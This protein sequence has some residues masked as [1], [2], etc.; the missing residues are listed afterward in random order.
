M[1]D[2]RRSQVTAGAIL[3]LLGVGFFALQFVKGIGDA[4]ILFMIGAL[5]IAGYFYSR[6]YGLLIPGC[7]LLGVGLGSVGEQ[8]AFAFGDL[9]LIGIG[10]GFVSI[11]LVDRIYRGESHWWPLIPGGI[12]L[13]LGLA[14]GNANFMRLLSL[15]WP[16]ILVLVGLLIL[17]GV[18]RMKDVDEQS[19][20]D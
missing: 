17:T 16:L 6:A 1:V 3:I 11:Y 9:G 19:D 5:F 14:E 20:E 2:Q 4:A 13:V 8:S 7:I 18:F 15:G 10:V 12:L